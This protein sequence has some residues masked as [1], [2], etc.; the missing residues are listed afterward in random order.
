MHMFDFKNIFTITRKELKSSFDN[1]TFYVNI[2]VF[3]LLWEF[4]FFRNA[5]LAGEASLRQL[6]DF[7][8]WL[9]IIF[10]PAV[11]MGAMSQEK[12]EGTLEL[13]LTHPVREYELLA[14]KFLGKLARSEERRVGKECRS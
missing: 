5:F 6:Y 2:A 8:P 13:L 7:L 12:S 11:T 4:L 10:I 3:L 9:L 1:P 14:G